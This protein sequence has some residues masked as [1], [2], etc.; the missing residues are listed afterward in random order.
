MPQR[1]ADLKALG[2]QCNDL[3][4]TSLAPLD[5]YVYYHVFS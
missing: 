1:L 2:Q 4:E 3:T 5:K